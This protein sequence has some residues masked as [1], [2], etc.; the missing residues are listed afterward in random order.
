MK[1]KEMARSRKTEDGSVIGLILDDAI[2]L[3]LIFQP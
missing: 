1:K 2:L 3:T